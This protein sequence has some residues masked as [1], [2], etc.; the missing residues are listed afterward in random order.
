[1]IAMPIAQT[2]VLDVTILKKVFQCSFRTVKS[3]P[4]ACRFA[5]SRILKN[6]LT[7]IVHNPSSCDVWI[8]ILILPAYTLRV[9]TPKERQEKRS[10]NRKALPQKYI[11]AAL[12]TWNEL[13]GPFKLLDTLFEETSCPPS[14]NLDEIPKR[15]N[16]KQCLRK[17][18]DGHYSAAVK[19]LTSSGIAPNTPQT[20]LLLQWKHPHAS[21]LTL[22]TF[23]CIENSILVNHDSVSIALNLS[24]KGPHLDEMA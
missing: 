8:R 14:L 10:G 16:M 5:F 2:R 20:R 24:L 17:I 7:A 15:D 23:P 6:V 1:M 13:G 19:V 3:I 11:F 18:S 21:A 12:T 22:P 9:F 4:S